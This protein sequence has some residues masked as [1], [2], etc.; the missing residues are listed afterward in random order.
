MYTYRTSCLVWCIICSFVLHTLNRIVYIHGTGA[1]V[2]VTSSFTVKRVGLGQEDA[3]AWLLSPEL[4]T[5]LDACPT[6]PLC[7]AMSWAKVMQ[8]SACTYK[9]IFRKRTRFL[10]QKRKYF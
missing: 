4:A 10:A 2:A 5:T 9:I 7:F 1:A 6:P 3:C 8:K